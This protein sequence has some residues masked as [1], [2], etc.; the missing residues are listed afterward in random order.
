MAPAAR[1]TS[2]WQPWNS[3]NLPRCT[4]THGTASVEPQ[5]RRRCM[6]PDLQIGTLFRWAQI[7]YRRAATPRVARGELELADALLRRHLT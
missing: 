7:A 1:M 3:F 2:P 5:A 4:S 6:G